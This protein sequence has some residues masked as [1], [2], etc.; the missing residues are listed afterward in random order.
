[1]KAKKLVLCIF[2]AISMIF[3]GSAVT[4]ADECYSDINMY[5][6]DVDIYGDWEEIVPFSPDMLLGHGNWTASGGFLELQFDT[7]GSHLGSSMNVHVQNNA[8]APVTVT[9]YRRTQAGAWI[10]ASVRGNSAVANPFTVNSGAG[11]TARLEAP[12][13]TMH[14]IVLRGQNGSPI[15]VSMGIR[16]VP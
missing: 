16:Q 6:S 12:A 14:R 13:N 8:T 1:M 2:L 10:R 4:M 11:P 15:S 9:V 5:I 7:R 3:V